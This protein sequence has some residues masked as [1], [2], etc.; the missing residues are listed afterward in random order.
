MEFTSAGK[1]TG[2]VMHSKITFENHIKEKV[3]KANSLMGV[4]GQPRAFRQGEVLRHFQDFREKFW[5][6]FWISL[7]VLY[8]FTSLRSQPA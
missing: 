2:V 7:Y 6:K 3:N 4:R 8:I 1:G 5:S